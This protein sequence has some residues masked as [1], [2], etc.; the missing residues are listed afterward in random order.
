MFW[1]NRMKKFTQNDFQNI[2]QEIE[3]IVMHQLFFLESQNA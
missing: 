2:N 1:T 3:K